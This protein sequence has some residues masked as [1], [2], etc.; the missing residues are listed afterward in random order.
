MVLF[1]PCPLTG[2]RPKSSFL[3]QGSGDNSHIPKPLPLV[4]RDIDCSAF[5]SVLPTSL[6]PLDSVGSQSRSQIPP[7]ICFSIERCS[8]CMHVSSWKLM[9]KLVNLEIGNIQKYSNQKWLSVK[10][11]ISVVVVSHCSAVSW[12]CVSLACTT[13]I[14]VDIQSNHKNA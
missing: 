12:S 8:A 14:S 9:F 13:I 7:S 11:S 3:G 4:G 6:V 10:C 1:R 2:A 5:L